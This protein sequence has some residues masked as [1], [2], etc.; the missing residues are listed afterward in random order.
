ME[1]S[2]I[3]FLQKLILSKPIKRYT[4]EEYLEKTFAISRN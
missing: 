4:L 2:T 3:D 1:T